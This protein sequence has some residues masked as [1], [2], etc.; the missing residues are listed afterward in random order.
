MKMGHLRKVSI[1]GDVASCQKIKRVEKKLFLSR[2]LE[3]FHLPW[4]KGAF[5]GQA[6]KQ[7]PSRKRKPQKDLRRMY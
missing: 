1:A 5:P 3:F 4:T 2:T 7:Q 6:P